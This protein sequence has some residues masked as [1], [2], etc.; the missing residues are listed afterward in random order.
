MTL[1][2]PIVRCRRLVGDEDR[3]HECG[4][5]AVIEYVDP[6]DERSHPLCIRHHNRAAVL[7]A[8]RIGL[9]AVTLT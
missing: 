1:A 5:P 3:E 6:K 7:E 8:E 2:E 4:R 9:I